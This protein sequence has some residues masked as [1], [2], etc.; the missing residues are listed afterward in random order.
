M[1]LT[2]ITTVFNGEDT[3][4]RAVSSVLTQKDVDEYIVVDD[5]STDNTLDILEKLKTE[6][7]D[8]RLSIV[9]M[10]LNSGAYACRNV[11]IKCS[12]ST[13]VTFQDA[14]DVSL[15]GRFGR[16]LP[17][18]DEDAV[19]ACTVSNNNLIPHPA[20][21]TVKRSLFDAI[22]Y[23]DENR[24]GADAEFIERMAVYLWGLPV[25]EGTGPY[26]RQIL[27]RAER[28]RVVQENLYL[29][30]HTDDGTRLTVRYPVYSNRRK[31]YRNNYRMRMKE[32]LNNVKDYLIK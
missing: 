1:T 5:C 23:F 32:C 20:T 29:Y 15:E 25:V 24:F 31:R 9:R 18:E 27:L 2:V 22:G 19:F 16:T 10:T 28:V 12:H 3:I 4:E 30:T 26:W 8:A 6:L 7:N 13:F 21:M 17:H 11:A 14:D